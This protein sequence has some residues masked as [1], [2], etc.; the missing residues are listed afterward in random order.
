MNKK[1]KK[2]G[3]ANGMNNVKLDQYEQSKTLQDT[4]VKDIK[5][6]RVVSFDSPTGSDD[7]IKIYLKE[8]R[9][10]PLLIKE[11]EVEIAKEIE[12]GRKRILEATFQ[13]PFVIKQILHIPP[14]MKKKEVPISSL[15][16]IKEDMPDTEKKKTLRKNLRTINEVKE[17]F[18]K[19][20]SY[21]KTLSSRQ[22]TR[23]SV[24]GVM[25]RLTENSNL[26]VDKMTELNIRNEILDTFCKQ[27]KNSAV[28]YCK[29]ARE[30][31]SLKKS[32]ELL[33][34][35]S[36]SAKAGKK[37]K[38]MKCSRRTG[39]NPLKI[40]DT[41]KE[42]NKIRSQL[43]NKM[44]LIEDE[45][46]L[47]GEAVMRNLRMFGEGESAIAEA[48]RKLIEAN[49]RLTVNIAKKYMRKGLGLSDLIQEGNIGLMKAVDKF[50]YKKGYKFS[51]YAT[52]WIKQSITR[53]LAD[54]SMTIRKP[55]HVV[56]RMNKILRVSQDFVQEFGTEPTDEEIAKRTNLPIE[57]V[58]ETL[59]ICSEPISI[60]TPIGHD[61]DNH[62]GDFLEDKTM[63]S[64]LESVIQNDLKNQI[65]NA[66]DTLSQKEV[67]I[68]KR[69]FGME[70][71]ISQTLEEVGS[72]L[73]VTRERIRQIEGNALKK[74]RHPTRSQ[75]L[76]SF[77]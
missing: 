27:F 49:L 62:L 19:R 70:D 2:R 26:L 65:K 56:D 59:K 34:R 69:R 64:P 25:S 10:I 29:L 52:W 6:V 45:L 8:M 44:L 46:G 55:V 36:I 32:K 12:Q 3:N 39:A 75:S 20:K 53:A 61:D 11:E 66:L 22:R 35:P 24:K 40:P 14:I 68:I 37:N 76:R 17:L 28:L 63:P 23:K 13:T 48:R 74:L 67:E 15:F 9:G 18:R 31:N 72:Q 7:P 60:E 77:L 5:R 43:K 54:Q 33:S 4:G 57:K 1:H 16:T 50:D 58:R 73:N 21:M 42:M 30:L 47:K 38:S 41:A 71:D 51:T